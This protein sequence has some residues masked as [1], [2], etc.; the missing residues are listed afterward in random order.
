MEVVKNY[1]EVGTNDMAMLISKLE[2]TSTDNKSAAQI[3][4]ITKRYH[5]AVKQ[6]RADYQKEVIDVYAK[7]NESGKII[8][9]TTNPNGFDIIEGKE[10]EFTKAAE[11]FGKKTYTF[12]GEEP[13]PHA[14]KRL[15]PTTLVD[16]KL[17]AKEIGILGDLYSDEGG[18]GVPNENNVVQFPI[19]N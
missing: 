18:P 15:T 7:K 5:A 19:K 3:Y 17:T 2:H 6:I 1:D 13:R 12:K 4:Q 9:S 16:V 10:E 11:D 8:P 14:F